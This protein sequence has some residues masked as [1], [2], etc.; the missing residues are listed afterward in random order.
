M[1]R[2]ALAGLVLLAL[3][4]TPGFLGEGREEHD[5]HREE[6]RG[7]ID[8]IGREQIAAAENAEEFK[9]RGDNLMTYQYQFKDREDASVTVP[10]IY[11]ETGETITIPLDQRLT[12]VENIAPTRVV[13]A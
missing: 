2:R 11:S 1:G 4:A 5:R 7:D 3:A 13:I 8:E 9:V 10:N 12:L 6:H